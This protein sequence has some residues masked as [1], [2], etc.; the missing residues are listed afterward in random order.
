MDI[1][2]DQRIGERRINPP[3]FR[4]HENRSGFDRRNVGRSRSF[5]SFLYFLSQNRLAM[6]AILLS[7]VILNLLDFFLTVNVLK[8][9]GGEL[10]PLMKY[11]FESQSETAFLFK[12]SVT[13]LLFSL[14]WKYRKF[15]KIVLLAV[16]MVATY[17]F[18]MAYH[19]FGLL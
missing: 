8:N 15:R 9:G 14:V 18:L 16:N 5:T 2:R 19:A 7:F 17:V 6:M 13:V 11:L 3:C 12:M 4:W 1:I 10:N